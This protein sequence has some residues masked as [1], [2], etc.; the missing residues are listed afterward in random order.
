MPIERRTSAVR[1][2]QKTTTTVNRTTSIEQRT[3]L[4]CVVAILN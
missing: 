2:Q 3:D 4:L 1:V